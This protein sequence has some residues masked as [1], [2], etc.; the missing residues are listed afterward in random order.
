MN[1]RAG[2]RVGSRERRHD[3]TR[4]TSKVRSLH[5]DSPRAM[6][7]P[8]RERACQQVK[9]RVRTYRHPAKVSLDGTSLVRFLPRSTATG[10]GYGCAARTS[11]T[12]TGIRVR[13]RSLTLF[14]VG[15]RWLTCKG[16]AM[17][18]TGSRTTHTHQCPRCGTTWECGEANYQDECPY[19][20]STLCI[21][22]WAQAAPKEASVATG[23]RGT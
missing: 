12:R 6:E 14:D 19:P 7:L 23:G 11:E 1:F 2:P 20:T 22:C 8:F 5:F 17:A 3:L 15:A 4:L 9:S 13:V 16:G 18:S 21:R 10:A